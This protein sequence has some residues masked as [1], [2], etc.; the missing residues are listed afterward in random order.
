MREIVHLR[1]QQH[2]DLCLLGVNLALDR[3]KAETLEARAG[4][5]VILS[6]AGTV[7]DVADAVANVDDERASAR[8]E[9]LERENMLETENMLEKERTHLIVHRFVIRT[10]PIQN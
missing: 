9:V 8:A 3:N 2:P 5:K 4:K 1:I 6:I 7:R 10:L